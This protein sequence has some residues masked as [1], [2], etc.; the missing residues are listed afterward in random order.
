MKFPRKIFV[1]IS[2]DED[3]KESWPVAHDSLYGAAEGEQPQPVAE[4]VLVR[5]TRVRLVAEEV[6]RPKRQRRG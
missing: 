6:S 1:T 2:A 4:Y 5:E 3:G